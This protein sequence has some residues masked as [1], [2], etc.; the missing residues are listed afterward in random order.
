MIWGWTSSCEIWPVW[1][2]HLGC[3]SDMSEGDSRMSGTSSN[4]IGSDPHPPPPP[5][6][7]PP[8]LPMKCNFYYFNTVGLY[9]K[10]NTDIIQA[11]GY[12]GH[13][14][15]LNNGYKQQKKI[16]FV[17][18]F[19]VINKNIDIYKV[20]RKKNDCLRPAQFSAT[21]RR[22]CKQCVIKIS[23]ENSWSC[24]V[25][26]NITSA[27]AIDIKVQLQIFYPFANLL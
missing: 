25:A 24:L 5:P 26:E 11:N 19:M 21:V 27:A 17:S 8:N 23:A 3:F 4:G 1:N 10:K 6:P 20:W 15:W 18:K 14:Q 9:I 2:P 12:T 13:I 22:L 7:P 16:S